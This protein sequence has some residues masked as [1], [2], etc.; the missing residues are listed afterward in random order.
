MKLTQ[1][2]I[3]SVAA[4]IA[5][6]TACS[7]DDGAVG[8]AGPQGA[9]GPAGE[10]GPAGPTGPEGPEGP[11]GDDGDQGEPGPAGGFGA[12]NV[13]VTNLTHGQPMAPTAVV[14]HEPGYY[15][16]EA[17]QPSSLGLEDLAEGGSPALVLSEASDA[18]QF[19][20]GVNTAGINGPRQTTESVTLVV[21]ELDL[22]NL[23]LSFATML[24]DTNDG[25]AG[26]A[27]EDI[28]NMQVGET[29]I[30]VAPVW[31]AG[32]EANTETAATMPGPAAQAAG[33]A[34][35]GFNAE[36]D[37]LVDA[38]RIHAGVVTSANSDD[39][40]LEALTTSALDQSDRFDNPGAR[41]VIT[42]TR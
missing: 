8:P 22:D 9:Q 30:I 34:A 33:G 24:I 21:P 28:S 19:L 3:L 37:D 6:L 7:G 20:D 36:R 14:V 29:R 23:R 11:Q 18:V 17:G 15:M 5:L 2:K 42:R 32:T 38:V 27:A 35:E 31:D 16:F 13:T 41:I 12:F 26:V 4:A 25:F 10:Q 40:S 1:F 39:P